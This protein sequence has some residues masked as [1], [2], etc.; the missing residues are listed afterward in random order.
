[1]YTNI[2]APRSWQGNQGCISK[3]VEAISFD[4]FNEQMTEFR[5]FMSE[6]NVED[7]DLG[8]RSLCFQYESLESDPMSTP[9]AERFAVLQD[10][11]SLRR[12]LLTN[13]NQDDQSFA[14]LICKNHIE[15]SPLNYSINPVESEEEDE[16]N[17]DMDYTPNW[18]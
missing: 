5:E 7:I 1:M 17:W 8:W 12:R 3:D 13:T 10:E 16:D 11:W 9:I 18:S 14:S 15:Q 4:Y 6:A 2:Q